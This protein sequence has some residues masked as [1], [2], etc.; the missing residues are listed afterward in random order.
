M[1]QGSLIASDHDFTCATAKLLHF[2]LAEVVIV[3][4]ACALSPA[5]DA[6]VAGLRGWQALVSPGILIGV[7]GC[8]LG[9][10]A[11]VFITACAR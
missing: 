10:F 6:T 11:G 7:L 4:N 9:N 2:S 5:T 8:A 3:S 1:H